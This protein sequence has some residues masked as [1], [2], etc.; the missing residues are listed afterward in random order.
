M[1][2]IKAYYGRTYRG[3][4]NRFLDFLQKRIDEKK[5]CFVVT[6]N[7]EIFMLGKKMPEMNR[8][9]MDKNTVIAAD[10]IGIVKGG[11]Q[12]GFR[13]KERIPGVELCEE[14]LKYA[15][16][17]K[18]SIYLFGA[19]REV[20][21][22][23]VRRIEK[24]YKNVIISGYTDGYVED[25]EKVMRQ[26]TE[27]DLDLVFVAL[28]APQQELLIHKYFR[29]DR[30]GIYIGVGGS[31]D[32]LSGKKQRAPSFFIRH[33]LEW[34]YRITKEPKRIK[35]F[36]NSN[37]KFLFELRK[38]SH[39]GKELINKIR[40]K[41]ICGTIKMI[42]VK[43]KKTERDLWNPPI[44]RVRKDLIDR[45]LRR[46]YS[47][48]VIYENH[49]GYHNIMMQRPQHMLRNMGDEETLIL[50]NSYYDIDFKDRRRITPIARHVYVLD[51]Y[52]YRKYL[53][54]ALKQIEKKY[55]MVYS[56]DTVPVSRIKQYSELGFRIIYEYVDDINEE[57]I[58][59]KKIAQIRSRHQYLLR[60]KNVLTVATADKLYKEAKSNNKKTR[61]V[62]ISN[63]A[64]CDKFVPESVTEDQVY[65]QWL[66]EDMLHV[67]YYG[68]LAAW[69]DYDLLKRL[70]DNEK[71]QLILI[72]IEH[73]DSLKKS[74]LL[75]YKN[76]KYFGKKPY[77]SLAGYVHFWDV[78]IIPFLINDITKATSPVKLFEYM[79][80]EKPVVSTALP[81]C[82]KYTAVK[83]AQ[84]VQEFVSLV[85]EC[86]DDCKDEKR[87]E[88]LKKCAWE[89]D[90]SVKAAELKR[91]WRMGEK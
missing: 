8:V 15:N 42:A 79:A 83:I 52:Y 69:V 73:D 20:L 39:G 64:E 66:K 49:F 76:V 16:E 84:N 68:A 30:K 74:G 44:S 56:T 26:I 1:A 10:G 14:L 27:L 72:G 17:K 40:K 46:G 6:A 48:I 65:R 38:E 22:S 2:S 21:D 85:E 47:R 36:W 35:R 70:A 45:I 63:G 90:W 54:N 51:L 67:G 41:G 86:K 31:F 25:K 78:C 77:E 18:C 23:F 24:E 71:I 53:L 87:K 82:L 80:M 89:N 55:V 19:K 57:L 3:S 75:D 61:I 88:L 28:G 91:I 7:P 60:A 32:V 37:V 13:F 59:R 11:E 12:L 5:G 9:L 58:S 29:S 33:N 43:W 34:L 81:E 4:K 62:Q 50:Y